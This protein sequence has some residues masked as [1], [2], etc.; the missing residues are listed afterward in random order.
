MSQ[1]Y[2][3]LG[4]ALLQNMA[5]SRYCKVG[6][7]SCNMWQVYY[8]VGQNLQNWTTRYCKVG[9]ILKSGATLLQSAA[10]TTKRSNYYKEG[11]YT[12]VTLGRMETHV[13]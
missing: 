10:G 4:Q 2:Y 13:Y 7:E 12:F 8:K 6:Q 3:E 9:Q 11:W 1:F 5:A